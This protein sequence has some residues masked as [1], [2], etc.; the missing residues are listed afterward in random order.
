[1][2]ESVVKSAALPMILEM[3]HAARNGIAETA[4]NVSKAPS[5][6]GFEDAIRQVKVD[7]Y[8]ELAGMVFNIIGELDKS[9]QEIHGEPAPHP[10]TNFNQR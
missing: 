3:L 8:N 9:H 2:F 4:D 1:M 5:E 6:G 10:R 7:T